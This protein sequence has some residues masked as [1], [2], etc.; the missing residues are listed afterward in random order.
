MK[1]SRIRP[2]SRMAAVALA[3]VLAGCGEDGI[4][5][6]QVLAGH[7]LAVE[8]AGP[9][10][11]GA[12]SEDRLELQADGDYVWTTTTFGLGGRAS[13]GMLEWN[14][15]A[16]DW[17]VDGGTLALRTT[18]GS[19]WQA[20]PGGGGA[21]SIMDFNGEWRPEYK[22]RQEADRL[23]LEKVIPPNVRVLPRTFVFERVANFDDAPQPPGGQ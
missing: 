21:W 8:Y 1:R 22:V 6:P 9:D 4:S 13:D 11:L 14:R 2:M 18:T 17:G 19:R 15:I 23:I 3:V 12:R 7:W 10:V 20:S 16:G 5:T